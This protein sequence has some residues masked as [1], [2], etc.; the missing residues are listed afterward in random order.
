MP[1]FEGRIKSGYENVRY[2]KT[3]GTVD[4]AEPVDT[5]SPIFVRDLTTGTGA[6][7]ANWFYKREF[8]IA[9]AGNQVIDLNGT[10]IQ[11]IF[12]TNLGMTSAVSVMVINRAVDPALAE[13]TTNVTMTTTLAGLPATVVLTPGSMFQMANAN[14]GG[15]STVVAGTGDTITLTNASG[16]SA[17]VQ[18]C[19]IG[20]G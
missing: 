14:A 19:V 18:I 20:R 16:A 10:A 8:N 6:N 7:M 17:R 11:D 2:V 1:A 4:Y 3:G 12:G 13:N 15:V 9:S 5:S